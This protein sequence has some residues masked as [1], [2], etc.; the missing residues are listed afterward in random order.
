[1]GYIPQHTLDNL[2]KYAY[3]GVDKSLVSRYVLNP[4]WTW[5]VTLWP[6]WVAPNTITLL[7]LCMVLVNFATMLY[8]DPKYLAEKGDADGPPQ[9]IYFTRVQVAL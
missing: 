2:K 7:G 8:Y 1:M 6:T 9:W 3:K 5:L 4:F